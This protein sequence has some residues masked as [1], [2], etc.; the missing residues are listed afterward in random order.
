MS[1]RLWCFAHPYRSVEE[2]HP[3]RTPRQQNHHLCCRRTA[4]L[5]EAGYL[6]LAPVCQTHHVARCAPVDYWDEADW[7]EYTME[8]MVRCDG[9]ILAPGWE[10]SEGCWR[11]RNAARERGMEICCYNNIMEGE[12]NG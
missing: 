1:E 4:R 11:E 8:L 6:V 12:T 7:L 10:D 2:P 9:I 5:I 3:V